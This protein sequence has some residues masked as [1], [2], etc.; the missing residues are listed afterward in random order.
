MLQVFGNTG[1]WINEA[2]YL[3]RG[4]PLVLLV[5]ECKLEE[6]DV[7]WTANIN[8]SG[9]LYKCGAGLFSV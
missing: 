6:A 5:F 3:H 7:M 2:Y 8:Q 1:W 4:E 9:L